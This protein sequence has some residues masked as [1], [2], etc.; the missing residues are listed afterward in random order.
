MAEKNRN[1]TG[2]TVQFLI[3]FRIVIQKRLYHIT[4]SAAGVSGYLSSIFIRH[5]AIYRAD[6]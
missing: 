1:P 4:V 5:K 3:T 6:L 2:S